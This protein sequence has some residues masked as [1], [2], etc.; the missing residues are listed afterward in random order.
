MS[1]LFL[2]Q[3][4]VVC[5]CASC[6]LYLHRLLAKLILNAFRFIALA[7]FLAHICQYNTQALITVASNV[8][9]NFKLLYCPPREVIAPQGGLPGEALPNG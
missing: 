3:K 5:L 8:I 2:C 9:K 4:S 1:V 7:P 6:S